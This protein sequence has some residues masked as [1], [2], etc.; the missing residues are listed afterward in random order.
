MMS[1]EDL[2]HALEHLSRHAETESRMRARLLACTRDPRPVS[3]LH[4]FSTLHAVSVQLH[5]IASIVATL[6]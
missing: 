5:A 6:P 2:T 1:N 4:E 3:V